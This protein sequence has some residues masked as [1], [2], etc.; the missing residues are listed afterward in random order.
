MKEYL[1]IW[2]V[3]WLWRRRHLWVCVIWL[4]NRRVMTGIVRSSHRQSV[5]PPGQ[6]TLSTL[7]RS[8]P[9]YYTTETSGFT[10]VK[11]AGSFLT[12]T[13]ERAG[14]FWIITHRSTSDLWTSCHHSTQQEDDVRA[15]RPNNAILI[16]DLLGLISS[17][18]LR[19]VFI[20]GCEQNREPCCRSASVS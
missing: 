11:R 14:R 10:S 15:I 19:I 9:V 3:L 20:L 1:I 12:G 18:D 17:G 4:I 5:T 6:Q 2:A 13:I 8:R 7:W 16:N